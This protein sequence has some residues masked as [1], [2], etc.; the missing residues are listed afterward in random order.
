MRIEDALERLDAIHAQVL[1]SETYR[2]FRALPTALTGAIAIVAATLQ[3]SLASP[4]DPTAFA[5]YW[6]AVAM[7]AI[8]V[9]ASDLVIF[10]MRGGATA[11]RRSLLVLRQIVPPLGVGAVI[12]VV[13]LQTGHAA[14]TLL[15]GLWSLCVGLAVISALPFLPRAIAIAAGF[16]FL[17]GIVLLIS[18]LRW[19]IPQP[20]GMGL[21][22]GIGQSITALAL[23]R[24]SESAGRE[25]EGCSDGT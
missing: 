21:T 17:A 11:R 1:R 24:G 2:G 22:F 19:P 12:T 16:Y 13:L 5:E 20:L 10:A 4:A 3:P 14:A 7:L 23:R 18:D 8:A 25:A 9:G 15:P 6:V